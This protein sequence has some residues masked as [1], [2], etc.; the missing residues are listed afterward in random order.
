ML[1]RSYLLMLGLAAAKDIKLV[2]DN[3]GQ[4][5]NLGVFFT[6]GANAKNDRGV[7]YPRDYEKVISACV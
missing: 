2:I 3:V 6:G 4:H 7:D 1:F 5:D